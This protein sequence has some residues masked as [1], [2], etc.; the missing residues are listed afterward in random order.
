MKFKDVFILFV[1]L[2]LFF[3]A[4]CTSGKELVLQSPDGNKE[5][6]IILNEKGQLFYQLK[7]YQQQIILASQLGLTG[8]INF[9]KALSLE[10]VE[11]KQFS[12]VWKPVWGPNN[13]IG[14]RY[15]ELSLTI[16]NQKKYLLKLH[17]RLFNDGL[18]FRY[19]IPRQSGLDSIIIRKEL[20]EFNIAQNGTAWSIPANF[21]SYEMLYR[22]TGISEVA[23]ANTPVTFKTDK[24]IYLSIHEANLTD[25]AGMTLKNIGGTNF[26]VNLV[27]WPDGVKVRLKDSLLS[28]WRTITISK[29]AAGL[30]E[31]NLIQNLNDPCVLDAADWIEPMKYIGI[32]WGMHL[33]IETWTMGPKHGAT[34]ENMKRY[35]DFAAD[36]HINAVLAEG[37]NTGWENWGKPKAFDQTTAYADFDIPEIVRYAKAKGVELIGHHET[38][39]DYLYYEERMEKAFQQLHEQ[40]IR[41]VKTGYAGPIPNGQHHHGQKMVQHYRKVVKMAAKYHLMVDAHEPI[42]ATG[43][44]RTYP[45]M[46][47]REGARGMEWNGWSAGNPPE[48]HVILPFTRC[49]GGPIDYTPGTFDILYKN[50]GKYRKWNSND[51]GNSR[52]N[53]TLAK[54]LALWVCLYSPLQ[55]ASDMISN[56]KDQPAFQFFKDL[57]ADFEASKVLAAEIGDYFAVARRKGDN[58]YIGAITDENAREIT[59]DLSFLKEKTKYKASIYADDE[60]TRLKD[61]PT[62]IKIMQRVVDCHT[63]LSVKMK[64]S[65]GQAIEIEEIKE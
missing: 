19:E 18:G 1:I 45:N 9:G 51:K 15:N 43:I 36:H 35:I 13:S 47:T 26:E 7:G 22:T 60:N 20:T 37:W 65:G 59:L 17:V 23:D 5:V 24:G 46:M 54:Q 63:K 40:G 34:T 57:P 48:H 16:Q 64:K 41:V 33:G 2:V 52:V 53:T 8:N 39:G 27:P 28:P 42:K 55:M 3:G 6:R 49:L 32:W 61:N 58:W 31:S 14:N 4:A 10:N 29:N 30:V 21:D 25:Y 62:A 11:R 50:R 38:G 44:S 56:Y 12:E